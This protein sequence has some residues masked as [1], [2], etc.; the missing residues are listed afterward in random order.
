[1]ITQDA[2]YHDNCLTELYRAANAKQLKGHYTNSERQLHGITLSEIISFTEENTMES[3]T[4]I[5]LFKLFDLTKM[6]TETLENM[7]YHVDGRIHSARLKNRILA[8]FE[9][10][11]EFKE[12]REVFLAFERDIGEALSTACSIDY[13]DEGYI[14]AEAAKIIRRD[15]FSHQQKPLKGSFEAGCQQAFVPTSLALVSMTVRGPKTNHSNNPYYTQA[16]LTL[17]QLII[18]NTTKKTPEYSH[19]LTIVKPGRH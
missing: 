9:D 16:M 8:H 6:Y 11:K 19:P 7:G 17:C 5:P 14:L 13:D 18:F 2:M 12:G 3:I 10:L 15:I 1:M 4:N